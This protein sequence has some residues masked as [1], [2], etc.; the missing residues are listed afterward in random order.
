MTLYDELVKLFREHRLIGVD[1]HRHHC[2][3]GLQFLADWE[4]SRERWEAHLAA[5]ACERAV[6]VSSLAFDSD[7][8]RKWDRE[9][10]A[11]LRDY[12]KN[13]LTAALREVKR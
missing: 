1:I 12:L 13:Q 4:L 8:T 7:G 9:G 11:E 10:D 5:L 2:S 6:E 3:C